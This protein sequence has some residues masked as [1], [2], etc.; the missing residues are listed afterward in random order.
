MF[1]F[2][3]TD[4]YGSPFVL[5]LIELYRASRWIYFPQFREVGSLTKYLRVSRRCCLM[6][7]PHGLDCSDNIYGYMVYVFQG[8]FFFK[9]IS[10]VDISRVFSACVNG[11]WIAP[12]ALGIMVIR[13]LIVQPFKGRICMSGL[14]LSSC[15]VRNLKVRALGTIQWQGCGT[16]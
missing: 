5:T 13:G 6:V 16:H 15:L 1:V 11:S 8:L 4:M 3:Y 2:L 12:L 9:W 7:G 10:R 14:C